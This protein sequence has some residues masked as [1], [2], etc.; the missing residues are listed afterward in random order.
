V[1]PPKDQLI[2]KDLGQ[3]HKKETM[4]INKA[5]GN[6]GNVIKES[7]QSKNPTKYGWL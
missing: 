6:K 7:R 1:D 5:Q 3:N 4:Q 2:R